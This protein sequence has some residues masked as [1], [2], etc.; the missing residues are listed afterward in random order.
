MK[1]IPARCGSRVYAKAVSAADIPGVRLT[2]IFS[3]STN[4]WY[5]PDNY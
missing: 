4:A 2:L 1:K 5:C 3:L